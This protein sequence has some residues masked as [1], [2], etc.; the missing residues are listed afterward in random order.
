MRRRFIITSSI[1]II[2]FA[3]CLFGINVYA[4]MNQSFS[5]SNTIGFEPS[6]S[7]YV[8]LD[9]K[10]SG[11]KQANLTTPPQ[12]S[13]YSTIEEYRQALG[14]VHKVDFNESMRG[15]D[16]QEWLDQE[17]NVW[18]IT[19]SLSFVD[20]STPIVYE[21]VVYNYSFVPIRVTIE[22]ENTSN[23]VITN[24]A[25]TIERLDAYDIGNQASFETITLTTRVSY[26]QR[27]K[28]FSNEPNNFKV[29]FEPIIE[30]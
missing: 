9:C 24:S 28:G 12:G 29:V 20:V 16:S 17:D 14:L 2:I 10:V 19:E 26:N 6:S 7:I 3:V 22:F 21:I 30:E 27:E 1:A 4:K 8:A 13:Q 25:T 18:N 23:S 5:I 15:E 11:C